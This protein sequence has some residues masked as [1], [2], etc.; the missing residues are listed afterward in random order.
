MY[1][2]YYYYSIPN[3]VYLDTIFKA[4][5]SN[6]FLNKG[7][8]GIGGTTLE[9]LNKLRC[10]IIVAPTR[11]ILHCKAKD[12]PELF[13]IDGNVKQPAIE[14]QLSKRRPS[15]KIMVTP[16]SFSRL[17]KA[18]DNVKMYD[19]VIKGWF[20]MLDECHTFITEVF[21]ENILKP[22]D[23][24]WK[25]D[26]KAII[27]ATPYHFSNP[28][29][30][31]LDYY[32][33]RFTE[34]LGTITLVDCLSVYA[35]IND[36]LQKSNV[37]KGNLHIYF[38]SVTGI[39]KCVKQAGLT[40]VS[41]YCADDE[42][43]AN[44]NKLGDLNKYYH[45][46][47]SKAN[48]SK[49]NFYT[50][51]YFEGID[52]NDENANVIVV[53]DIH[54]PHTKVSVA[55]K[56]KQAV[57]RL[58]NKPAQV[59][60]LTNHHHSNAPRKELADLQNSYNDEARLLIS[61]TIEYLSLC[62]LTGNKPKPD[63]RVRH[64]ANVDKHTGHPTFSYELFDQQVNESYSNEIYNNLA[65]IKQEWEA[66]YFDVDV[67]SSR[68]K[69]DTTTNMKRKSKATILK[70]DIDA[71]K[72]YKDLEATTMVFHLGQTIED[73]IKARNPLAYEAE[74][75]LDSGKLEELKYNCKLVAQEV[76]VAS[77]LRSEHKLL[78][79]LSHTFKTGQKYSRVS[80]SAQLQAIYEKL[81]IRDS[82]GKIRKAEATQLAEQGRFQI[83]PCKMQG[84]DVNGFQ[85]LGMQF[86]LKVAA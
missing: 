47:P 80:I 9:L 19:E 54:Q 15:Q 74:Q 60:H 71:L 61:Q 12:H 36:I 5:P 14:E 29:F 40:D 25:F 55:M 45:E 34:K 83:H 28:K 78:K 50:C 39:A 70:E 43:K 58:R 8:C 82:N 31:A 3:N 84:E 16:D 67:Q 44:M 1:K 76:I 38:N 33:I 13:I 63:D 35:T 32:E 7:R 69:L 81:N 37:V 18:I 51:K 79:L 52:I 86:N 30:Q 48:Q 2:N 17:I 59:I 72:A 85:I 66:G 27:S 20:L 10:S 64:F 41:I 68:A 49:V 21:R 56:L 42:D 73:E 77:N 6:A 75:F 24:F 23:Y 22:F 62:E 65:L 11:G 26:H 53:T 46:L 57:G 4:I